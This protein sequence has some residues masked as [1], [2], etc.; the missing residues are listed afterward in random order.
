[1]HIKST[2]EMLTNQIASSFTLVNFKQY[3]AVFS[4]FQPQCNGYDR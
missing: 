3:L 4:Q 2:S 1:M